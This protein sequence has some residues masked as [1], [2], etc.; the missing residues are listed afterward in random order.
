MALASL[1]GGLALAN[2][3]LGA[4]HGLAAPLGGMTRVPHGVACAVLLPHVLEAN[5]RACPPGAPAL[6]RFG[7]LARLLTGQAEAVP[8]DGVR[9]VQRLVAGFRLPGLGHY[10]LDV[11]DLER[12]AERGLAASS[13]KA[14]PVPLSR[15]A[16][17]AILAKAI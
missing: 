14:N 12:V 8:L 13:M 10:G 16:L 4:V 3:G 1:L 5:L 11:A 6:A 2:A 9:W 7:E 15:E 17:V